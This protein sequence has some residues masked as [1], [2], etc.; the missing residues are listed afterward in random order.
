VPRSAERAIRLGVLFPD[1]RGQEEYLAFPSGA[2]FPLE[3]R[4]VI[5]PAEDGLRVE[6]LLRIG[7][8]ERLDAAARAL[9]PWR[10]HALTWA[11]TSGSFVFGRDGARRQAERIAAAAGAPAGSTS[12]AFLDAVRALGIRRVTLVSPY[13]PELAAH[14]VILLA[15]GGV[16]VLRLR[17]LDCA[18]TTAAVALTDEAIVAAARETDVPAAEALLLPDTALQGLRLIAPLQARLGKP[19]LTANQVTLWQALRLAGSPVADPR[20]GPLATAPLPHS[21]APQPSVVQPR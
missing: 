21:A 4:V 8:E 13:L 6:D 3:L 10:P 1:G 16:E 14:F 9:V 15:A 20:L 5:T 18:T 7:G 11:C 12:L 17:T 19:V 2:P